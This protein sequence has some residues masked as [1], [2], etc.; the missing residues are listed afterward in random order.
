MNEMFDESQAKIRARPD[1][2]TE[3]SAVFKLG[4]IEIIQGA[5]LIS[6]KTNTVLIMNPYST[7]M[8]HTNLVQ[9]MYNAPNSL[10]DSG[11]SKT[12]ECMMH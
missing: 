1:F 7:E 9:L 4:S 12:F 11:F 10:K 8:M 2:V 3:S 6:Y 5:L